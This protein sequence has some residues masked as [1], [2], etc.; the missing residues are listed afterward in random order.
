M[1]KRKKL[2][3]GKNVEQLFCFG[4]FHTSRVPW[5]PHE[6]G[7]IVSGRGGE[8]GPDFWNHKSFTSCWWE[9]LN[10]SGLHH[11]VVKLPL[12]PMS[13]WVPMRECLHIMA[14]SLLPE[15]DFI[16]NLIF[17]YGEQQRRKIQKSI[18]SVDTERSH[19]ILLRC[20]I[21]SL[22]ACEL[23]TW[24][25]TSVELDLL[26]LDLV[27]ISSCVQLSNWK[28]GKSIVVSWWLK[29]KGWMRWRLCG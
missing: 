10:H 22:V 11:T 9:F 20:L 15:S 17:S 18:F 4:F 29:T 7:G 23:L 24:W 13:C 8:L 14:Q 28:D 1:K 5:A 19:H 6:G 2:E 27:R 12:T 21:K 26:H 25:Q 16:S 3:V